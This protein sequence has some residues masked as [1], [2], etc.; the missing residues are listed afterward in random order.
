MIAVAVNNSSK[1]S[2]RQNQRTSDTIRFTTVSP[3]FGLTF[4]GRIES[5]EHRRLC[6]FPYGYSQRLTLSREHTTRGLADSPFRPKRVRVKPPEHAC[7]GYIRHIK[8]G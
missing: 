1:E 4:L 2:W 3:L 7:V 6:L 5:T 8:L